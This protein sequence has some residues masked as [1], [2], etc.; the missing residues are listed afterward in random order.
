MIAVYLWAVVFQGFIIV[1]LENHAAVP[2]QFYA[3]TQN[4]GA[5]F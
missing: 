1:N 4:W 2:A 3:S 5:W